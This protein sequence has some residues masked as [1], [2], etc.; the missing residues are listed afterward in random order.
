MKR[1]WLASII[2]IPVLAATGLVFS[3]DPTPAL[4]LNEVVLFEL[5]ATGE[6]T[7]QVAANEYGQEFAEADFLPEGDGDY[8]QGDQK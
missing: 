3:K 8:Y 6:E 7:T 1:N 4:E 2:L 5:P